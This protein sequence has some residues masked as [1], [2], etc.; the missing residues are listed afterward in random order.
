MGETSES[1][2]N[3]VRLVLAYVDVLL[4]GFIA[5]AVRPLEP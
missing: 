5:A 2:M 3:G 1:H 4:R